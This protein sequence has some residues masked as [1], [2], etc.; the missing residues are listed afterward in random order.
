MFMYIF[1]GGL[2]VL[3]LFGVY[4]VLESRTV[5][6]RLKSAVL[7]YSVIWGFFLNPKASLFVLELFFNNITAAVVENTAYLPGIRLN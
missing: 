4:Q 1:L 5:C 6:I 3:M 2:V 7:F